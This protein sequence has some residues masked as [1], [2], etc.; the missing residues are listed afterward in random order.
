M[1]NTLHEKKFHRSSSIFCEHQYYKKM[2]YFGWYVLWW[3]LQQQEL[4][5]N[6]TFL[7]ILYVI[8]P[9]FLKQNTTNILEALMTVEWITTQS[10][11]FLVKFSHNLAKYRESCMKLEF[12]KFVCKG[13]VMVY[14][15]TSFG[16]FKVKSDWE[17][18]DFVRKVCIQK[19]LKIKTFA[20]CS[21]T[22]QR[23]QDLKLSH[24]LNY[25][26]GSWKQ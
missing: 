7:S 26:K 2:R 23:L 5:Q 11:A 25:T 24:F 17:H 19:G 13:I 21:E 6:Q 10:F 16:W 14:V 3:H 18:N 9:P 15:L 4:H 1:E 8:H 12:Q 22:S 20:P